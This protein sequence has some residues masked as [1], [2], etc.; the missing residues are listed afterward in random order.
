MPVAEVLQLL[1]GLMNAL[2]ELTNAITAAQATGTV[3][4]A[5]I[6]AIFSKYG[7]D[8]AVLASAIASATAAGK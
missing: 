3:P 7:L 4:A 1:L 5:T 8:R 6:Q 2:P